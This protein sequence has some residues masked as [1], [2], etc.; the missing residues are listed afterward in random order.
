MSKLLIVA[1]LGSLSLSVNDAVAAKSQ[2]DQT[3]ENPKVVTVTGP[4]YW[5]GA[6][7]FLY[8]GGTYI[9]DNGATLKL[10]RSNNSRF[11]IDLTGLPKTEVFAMSENRFVANNEMIRLTFQPHDSGFET[12]LTVRY[13][14]KE[15]LGQTGETIERVVIASN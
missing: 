6:D 14:L 2:V 4:K 12:K 13:V 7:E 8:L 11:F 9:L 3:A 15:K 1:L 5:V 10:S